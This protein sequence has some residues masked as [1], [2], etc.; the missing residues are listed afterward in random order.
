MRIVSKIVSEPQ[1]LNG[2]Y[3]CVKARDRIAN[4]SSFKM[5]SVHNIHID[6]RCQIQKGIASK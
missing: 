4:I 6:A 5:C 2:V 3:I 1:V